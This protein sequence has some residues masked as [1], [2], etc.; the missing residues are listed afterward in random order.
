MI[1]DNTQSRLR[2][3]V[4]VDALVSG[5]P[6]SVEHVQVL[7][8]LRQ[9]TAWQQAQQERLRAH[10]ELQIARLRGEDDGSRGHV[11]TH[12]PQP[13]SPRRR[14]PSPSSVSGDWSCLQQVAP[15][16][17]A[18]CDGSTEEDP[19]SGGVSVVPVAGEETGSG[20]LSDSGL[21]TGGGGS[22]EEIA[23]GG[24]REAASDTCRP[25]H[26]GVGMF[27]YKLT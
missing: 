6:A 4:D 16:R 9:L 26:P 13:L 23:G 22:E 7:E 10:Q 12:Q 20:C 8:R 1:T 15:G 18:L 21:G 17:A 11:T 24:R 2:E 14:H 19:L 3:M 25:I 27:I 5:V